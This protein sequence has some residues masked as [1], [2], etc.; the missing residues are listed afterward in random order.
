MGGG[1]GHKEISLSG[2]IHS[3]FIAFV[4]H[5]QTQ[6]CLQNDPNFHVLANFMLLY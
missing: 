3:D 5:K 6:M 1:H 4:S 2:I